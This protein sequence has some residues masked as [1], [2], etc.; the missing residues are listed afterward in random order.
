MQSPVFQQSVGSL[1]IGGGQ[2]NLVSCFLTTY[3]RK[4]IRTQCIKIVGEW[5]KVMHAVHLF[6]VPHFYF[7]Q[8]N[9][10]THLNLVNQ[11]IIQEKEQ[12]CGS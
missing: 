4:K 3:Q 11:T 10:A 7:V 6:T 1:F 2:V 8:L 5:H 12:L 9:L